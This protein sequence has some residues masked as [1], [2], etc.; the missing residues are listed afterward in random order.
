MA[1]DV[2]VG[3]IRRTFKKEPLMASILDLER[4]RSLGVKP[5]DRIKKKGPFQA[6]AAEEVVEIPK[7]S[8]VE[9][10]DGGGEVRAFYTPKK[11]RMSGPAL[12]RTTPVSPSEA[13]GPFWICTQHPMIIGLAVLFLAMVVLGVVGMEMAPRGSALHFLS[14]VGVLIGV[15]PGMLGVGVVLLDHGVMWRIHHEIAP[16]A[17][18]CLPPEEPSSPIP[19]SD[20]A[21]GVPGAPAP[22]I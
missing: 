20:M 18:L 17:S 16:P 13:P 6:L 3:Q 2:S 19:T 5:L 14:F 4:A 11:G 21:A 10:V 8:V 1:Q 9:V 12:V 15:G 7:S 22:P